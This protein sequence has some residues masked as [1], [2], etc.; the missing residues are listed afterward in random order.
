L[1]APTTKSLALVVASEG[2]VTVVAEA[3]LPPSEP[4]TAE[5][6][7][8]PDHS[9]T[10]T[11]AVFA[12]DNVAVTL[13]TDVAARRYQI[14]TRVFAPVRNP[15]GPFVHVPPAESVT[16]VTDAELPAANATTATRA[17]PDVDGDVNVTGRVPVFPLA[18]FC[19]TRPIEPPPPPPP[20]PLTVTVTVAGGESACPSFTLYVNGSEPVKPGFDVYVPALQFELTV[21]VP[22]EGGVTIEQVSGSPSGSDTLGVHDACTAVVALNDTGCAVGGVFPPAPAP[23]HAVVP[24]SVNVCPASGTN[25]QS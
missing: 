15:T 1:I 23:W 21:A 12:A 22:F 8:T 4:S 25:C 3:P 11:A 18:T 14:S 24:E 9:V 7:A 2:V 20:P 10:F 19:W 16:L 17:F 5:D 6:D 13:V